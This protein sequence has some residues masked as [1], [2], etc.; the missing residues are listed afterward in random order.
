MCLCVTMN[1]RCE[2]GRFPVCARCVKIS[3][4]DSVSRCKTGY[5]PGIRGLKMHLSEWGRGQ[6]AVGLLFIFQK[7]EWSVGTLQPGLKFDKF[8]PRLENGIF[9]C[10]SW[11]NGSVFFFFFGL[12]IGVFWKKKSSPIYWHQCLL[13]SPNSPTFFSLHI[14]SLWRDIWWDSCCQ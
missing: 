13:P 3:N 6:K 7:K 5:H 14:Y 4:P 2:G 9:K 12:L 1:Y 10:I 8:K 11:L